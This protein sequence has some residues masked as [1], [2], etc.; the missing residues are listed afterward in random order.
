MTSSK[1]NTHALSDWDKYR[2]TP[3]GLR[4]EKRRRLGRALVGM[5]LLGLLAFCAVP[6]VTGIAAAVAALPLAAL[7]AGFVSFCAGAYRLR[8]CGDAD[9]MGYLTYSTLQMR[10]MGKSAVRQQKTGARM[11]DG[12]IFAGMSPDTGLPMF[13]TPDDAPLS[14]IGQA[15]T[16][17]EAQEYAKNL[18]AHGHKDW[19]VPTKR[20]LSVLFNNRAKIGNFVPGGEYP[21][22]WYWSSTEGDRSFMHVKQFNGGPMDL[23]VKDCQS[24]L[25]CVRG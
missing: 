12:T 1:Q 4:I 5:G 8:Q 11:K 16:Y 6:V 15:G 22:G 10:M 14:G 21:S 9:E 23:N 13:A 17:A 7:A 18:D 3:K 24:R 20:E 19:R 25:R 2:A